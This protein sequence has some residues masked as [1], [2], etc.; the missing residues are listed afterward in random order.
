MAST[1]TVVAIW[2][3]ANTSTTDTVYS[4]SKDPNIRPITSNGTPDL[5]ILEIVLI[6][7]KLKDLT[8]LKHLEEGK[9]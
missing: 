7:Q 2:G 8:M 3:I 4:S 6:I 9:R 5:P 1:L